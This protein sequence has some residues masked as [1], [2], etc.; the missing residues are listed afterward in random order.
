MPSR[1]PTPAN[2][3]GL[4]Y[5]AEARRL[6]PPPVPIIDVHTH[7]VGERAPEVYDEAARLY[8]VSC[9]LTMTPLEKADVVRDR[10]GDRVRFI[11]VP[12]WQAQDRSHAFR[13]G[14]LDDIRAFRDRFDARIVKIWNAPRWR[15]YCEGPHGDD[16]REFDSPWRVRIVELA[17]DL[18]MMVM[19][20]IADPDTWFQTKYA[21]VRKYGDKPSQYHAFER[22][23]ERFP[24]PWIA[25]HMGGWPENLEFLSGL[26]GRHENLY[27]D[28]S[29][30]K[31]QVRELSRHPRDDLIAFFTRWSG[32]ILFG[33]DVVTTDEHLSPDSTSEHPVARLASTSEEAF[34]LYASRYW[35]MRTMFETDYQ[36][37]SPIADPDL[38]LID[39]TRHH[40][41]SAPNLRG[42]S[43]PRDLLEMLYAGAARRLFG[44]W[45][46]QG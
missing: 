22:M 37:E 29:A 30:T 24:G 25:A 39:P 2:R 15:D 7:I 5:R 16:M 44:D 33:T 19:A 26:L 32:R 40:G 36:G 41:M 18:G 11:A 45:L 23:V 27:L 38:E 1:A 21:D 20:H 31:W 42:F 17:Q 3:L 28:C 35:A 9:T 12:N 4:D 46:P 8:G 34:E 6:G 43:L 14:Y 10:L 13:E